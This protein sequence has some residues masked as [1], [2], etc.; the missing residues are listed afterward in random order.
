MDLDSN[1]VVER[2]G[3]VRISIVIHQSH[4]EVNSFIQAREVDD[5]PAVIPALNDL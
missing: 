3:K 5:V 2:T 1:D 4:A